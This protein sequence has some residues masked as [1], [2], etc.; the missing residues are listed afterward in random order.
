VGLREVE[1]AIVELEQLLEENT[2]DEA[3][4]QALFEMYP[5]ILD[6][7]GYRERLQ[8]PRLPKRDGGYFEPDFLAERASGLWQIVD[9][10]TPAEEPLLG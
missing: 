6:V 9:L 3:N 1:L 10:K 4:Y 5:D 2:D 8:R 7:L